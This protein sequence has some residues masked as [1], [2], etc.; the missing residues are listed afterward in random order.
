MISSEHRLASSGSGVDRG[1]DALRFVDRPK[2]IPGLGNGSFGQQ[3]LADLAGR[4]DVDFLEFVAA[5]LGHVLERRGAHEPQSQFEPF[6][7]QQRVE[8]LMKS[9]FFA[10]H[11]NQ[12]IDRRGRTLRLLEL[13]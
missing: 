6:L 13:L 7:H 10:Q 2:V 3:Q 12:V 8:E 1:R 4:V 11:G 5:F 9:L